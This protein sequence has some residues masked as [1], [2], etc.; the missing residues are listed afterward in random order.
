MYMCV[1]VS[2]VQCVARS[3]RLSCLACVCV[4]LC[5]QEWDSAGSPHVPLLSHTPRSS[6]TTFSF[7]LVFME[8][9]PQILT[10]S[11]ITIKTRWHQLKTNLDRQLWGESVVTNVWSVCRMSL[12]DL[13][14]LPFMCANRPK[15]MLW[16]DCVMTL[17]THAYASV[18]MP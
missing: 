17:V 2:S 7:F 8:R 4:L 1:C 9:N 3:P 18:L 5:K 14:Y 10:Y 16:P 11:R 6:F 13:R 12:C 15:K